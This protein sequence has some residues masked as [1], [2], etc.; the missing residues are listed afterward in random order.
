M[1]KEEKKDMQVGIL[2]S[3]QEDYLEAIYRLR[4]EKGVPRIKDIAEHLDVMPASVVAALKRL[5]KAGLINYKAHETVE[6]TSTGERLA[7]RIFQRHKIITNF[8]IEI[9]DLDRETSEREACAIEHHLGIKT[10]DKL[11]GFLEFIHT[12]PEGGQELLKRFKNFCALM[13]GAK[14]CHVLEAC[15][16]ER[17]CLESMEGIQ[18]LSELKPGERGKIIQL[19]TDSELR[20]RL[21]DLGMVPGSEVDV[22][23]T[24]P[25][26]DPIELG[27][28]GYRLSLRKEEAGTIL[29]KKLGSG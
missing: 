6:M 22:I 8:F 20:Q 28:L 29:V 7:R 15:E 16:T 14:D 11:V 19:R 4:E 5:N 9:L 23:R 26:G 2:S 25:L 12:C 24:A 1:G 27:L 18:Y 10:I 3:S 21:I 17:D 13:G